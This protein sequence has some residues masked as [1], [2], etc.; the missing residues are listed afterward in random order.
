[1]TVRLYIELYLTVLK[2]SSCRI[3]YLLLRIKE[4]ERCVI[5]VLLLLLLL[6][7]KFSKHSTHNKIVKAGIVSETFNET[8]EAYTSATI[9]TVKHTIFAAIRTSN[10][11]KL[12]AA[13]IP[14]IA[15]S[16]KI[17]CKMCTRLS[18]ERIEIFSTL[19]IRANVDGNPVSTGPAA[20]IRVGD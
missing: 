18:T 6:K 14:T 20:R 4:R 3:D 17:I 12:I 1:M 13:V 16:V 2:T 5:T 9:D 10:A 8:P 7:Y 15:V 11:L 19:T